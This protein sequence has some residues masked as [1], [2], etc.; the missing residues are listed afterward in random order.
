MN[1]TRLK[2]FNAMC[3][4]CLLVIG[5]CGRSEFSPEGGG[6][7]PVV[8]YFFS[9]PAEL[10]EGG[11]FVPSQEGRYREVLV[12]RV[13]DWKERNHTRFVVGGRDVV[14][15]A[16]ELVWKEGDGGPYDK[17]DNSKDIRTLTINAETVKILSPLRVPG[18][19]V[20]INARALEVGKGGFLSITPDFD[21]RRPEQLGGA[22]RDGEHAGRIVL[23]VEELINNSVGEPILIARGGRGQS[24]ALG[25]DGRNGASVPT[26]GEGG[27]IYEENVRCFRANGSSKSIGNNEL[28][29]LQD[30]QCYVVE[31]KGVQN[32]PVSGEDAVPGGRPGSSGNG[33]DIVTNVPLMDSEVD[34]SP[35]GAGSGTP[36]YVGGTAGTPRRAMMWVQDMASPNGSNGKAL[37]HHTQDGKSAPAL[38]AE[39][40]EGEPGDILP[41]EGGIVHWASSGHR[42]MLQRQA[43]DFYLARSFEKA[44]ELYRKSLDLSHGE[45]RESLLLDWDA[46]F[47]LQKLYSHRDFFF[48]PAGGV[49]DVY[50]YQKNGRVEDGIE[51]AMELLYRIRRLKRGDDVEG[52]LLVD[53][54]LE[55]RKRESE[56]FTK[57]LKKGRRLFDGGGVPSEGE[58]CKREEVFPDLFRLASLRMPPVLSDG[59][60]F[61]KDASGKEPRLESLLDM[62]EALIHA[63]PESLSLWGQGLR[64]HSAL[65]QGIR[66]CGKMSWELGEWIGQSRG[67]R[68]EIRD[69]AW[70]AVAAYLSFQRKTIKGDMPSSYELDGFEREVRK[71]LFRHYSDAVRSYQYYHLIP[72][73]ELFPWRE[74]LSKADELAERGE[75]D[76]RELGVF[77]Q[78]QLRNIFQP[79]RSPFS[80]ADLS[81]RLD[82][83]Q[84]EQLRRKGRLY[85]NL[86][87]EREIYRGREGVRI[88]TVE[89]LVESDRGT[90]EYDLEVIHPGRFYIQKDGKTYYGETVPRKWDE[91]GAFQGGGV[92]RGS[93]SEVT[94]HTEGDF[95]NI[96]EHDTALAPPLGG[97]TQLVL[98][99]G[100]GAELFSKVVLNISYEYLEGDKGEKVGDK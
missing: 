43:E 14:I 50:F 75:S 35:G 3:L 32:W 81:I 33:G 87:D 37:V 82:D 25:R 41:L 58:D 36:D 38:G 22:G 69:F 19:D 34:L 49:P 46:R 12:E 78:E 85:L 94:L 21:R 55:E 64:P 89:L 15:N 2:K 79:R 48:R 17:I 51:K 88:L 53:W 68:N 45:E 20:I 59:E 1:S 98:Q 8:P 67:R 90:G 66:F 60:G 39:L 31:S 16:V 44:E 97:L 18:A 65:E 95:M 6:R 47:Q 11:I 77:Y 83:G 28:L 74:I 96:F 63:E 72:W 76:W 100:Q 80:R 70:V 71:V 86:L 23:N 52:K 57:A 30:F 4:V 73:R 7:E 84:L 61:G 5:G 26:I 24:G 56:N 13:E 54:S 27:L 42:K 10:L 62:S 92:E 93:G 9:R 99:S 91:R 40:E 29:R